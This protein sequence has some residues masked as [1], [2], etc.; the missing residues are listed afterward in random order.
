MTLNK[1]RR[2]RIVISAAFFVLTS[3]L[4]IELSGNYVR[5]FSD[6]ILFFQF[7]PS[8]VSFIHTTSI[9][10]TGFIVF[11]IVALLFGRI[12]CSSI[13]P[14][15]FTIDLINRAAYK[16][17]RIKKP[18][19]LFSYKKPWN[20]LRYSILIV[21]T[22]LF[23]G[24]L[25]IGIVLLDPFGNF[26][27][28][29]TKFARPIF[30]ALNNLA[31]I[32]LE[33]FD[34]FNLTPYASDVFDI[35]FFIYPLLFLGLLVIISYKR[36]RFYCNTVCPV[37]ALLGWLSNYSF[38]KIAVDDNSCIE[39]GLCEKSCKA[40]C[41]NASDKYVD[42]SRCVSC[43][44]CF[45]SCNSNSLYFE[46][47]Y[48]KKV[49]SKATETN[50]S[51]R[52]FFA[53]T[54]LMTL[55]LFR[56]IRAQNKV[57]VYTENT[58]PENRESPISPPGSLS[59]DHFVTNCTACTLCVSACPTKVLQPSI[60][61]YGIEGLL[62]PHMNNRAGYCNYECTVCSEVCPNEAILPIELEAKKSTQ[63]G[64]VEFVKDNCVVFTQKTECGA[65][66]EHCPTKA[67]RMVLD[68]ELNLRVPIT[69]NKICVGCGACEYACPT[70]PY[71]AIYIKGNIVHQI[72]EKPVEEEL[73]MPEETDD[74]PF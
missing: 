48:G 24:G 70:I 57:L 42:M 64:R 49:M 11:M 36:G 4:F 18:N 3:L 17:A 14:L 26:G 44:N 72:A 52:N 37:G 58:I 33:Q 30:V 47:R 34:N 54:G 20:K 41:I 28:L 40:E 22:L 66:A 55:A 10:A 46:R 27:R 67:V 6:S 16:L 5:T 69:D 8:L 61:E 31:V 9:A 59:V 63:I 53:S 68:P 62:M 74:F 19:R 56:K 43:F 13:C 32:T 2:L 7:I 38:Y 65:C 15:G 73:Q 12:Y 71:K 1:F 29:V 50:T 60:F 23:A 25:S 35:Q 45:D 51:R 39:C 21:A